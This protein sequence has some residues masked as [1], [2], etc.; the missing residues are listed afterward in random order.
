MSIYEQIYKEHGLS[1]SQQQI[2]K[3]ASQ[4]LEKGRKRLL[5]LGSSTGYMTQIFKKMGFAV[6]IVENDSTSVKKAQKYSVKSFIGSLDD[7][8]LLQKITDKYDV[9]VAADVLEHLVNPD[10]VLD[11]MRKNLSQKGTIIISVPNIASW[12]I[13]KD[14]F[15][16]GQF[17][18][19]ESGILDKTHL[20]FFNF[21]TI[22]KLL[23]KKDFKIKSIDLYEVDYPLRDTI[24]R[25]P[26]IGKILLKYFD[27]LMIKNYPNLSARHLVVEVG[28]S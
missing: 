6:D 4:S 8:K 12:Q 16:K 7:D 26:M 11:S 21:F 17:E 14:L 5:E 15:F 23:E 20:I 27:K 28:T 3:I 9:I 10:Q 13:R 18:Y 1:P 24:I 22:Q 2:I 19:Q 25:V